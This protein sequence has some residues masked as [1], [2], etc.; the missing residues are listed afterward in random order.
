[1]LIFENT[2][3]S[4]LSFFFFFGYAQD[5]QKFLGRGLNPGH[6]SDSARSSTHWATR[7]LCSQSFLDASSECLSAISHIEI[8]EYP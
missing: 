4:S 5:M 3:Y 1:M 7:E 8:W 6:S 2:E